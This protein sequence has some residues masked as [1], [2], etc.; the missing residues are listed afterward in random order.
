MNQGIINSKV[1]R[2]AIVPPLSPTF[3][4]HYHLQLHHNPC[5]HWN[6]AASFQNPRR[7]TGRVRKREGRRDKISEREREKTDN[8]KKENWACVKKLERGKR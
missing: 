1:G 6:V 4:F 5:H 7:Q 8:E 3:S 2:T